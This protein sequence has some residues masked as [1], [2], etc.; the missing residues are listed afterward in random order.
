[1]QG[2]RSEK[3]ELM[4]AEKREDELTEEELKEQN[5]EELPDR[6]AMSL[7]TPPG[8]ADGIAT[9]APVEPPSEA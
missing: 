4:T 5:G 3:E 2:R 8:G 9:I 6:E 1:M 7:I